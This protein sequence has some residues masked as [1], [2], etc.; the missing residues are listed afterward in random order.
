[1]KTPHIPRFSNAANAAQKILY[2]AV[3]LVLLVLLWQ[4]IVSF[5]LVPSYL[6]PSPMQVLKALV[7]DASLL[8][9][10]SLITLAEALLGLFWGVVFGVLFAALMDWIEPFKK[11]LR[12][13]LT[14]TQAV[15]TVAI[16][17]L[18]VLWLGYGML[19]KVVLVALTCFF[20][21]AISLLEGFQA[22]SAEKHE[23]FKTMRASKLQTFLYLK[24][25]TSLTYFFSGLKVGAAYAIVGAVIAEWLGGSFGLGVY[26]T[27]VR[28]SYAYDQMFAVILVIAALSLA[29]VGIVNILEKIYMPWEHSRSKK[30]CSE[31]GCGSLRQKSWARPREIAA[32]IFTGALAGASALLCVLACIG[33]GPFAQ[34][35]FSGCARSKVATVGK[36]NQS[37]GP[38]GTNPANHSSTSV[39]FVLD[40]TPNTNH[41]GIYAALE[42]GFYADAGI[43]LQIVQ[44]PEDGAEAMVGSG[45][46]DFG[47]SYQDTLA[48]YLFADEPVP[49]T[50]VAAVVQHNTSGIMSAAS[51]NIVRPRDLEA[52]TYATMQSKTEEAILKHLIEADGGDFNTVKLVPASA[53]DEVSGLKAQL[54]DAIW[55]F[56]GWGVQNAQLKDFPVRFMRIADFNPAFD[57][58]TPVIIA[59]NEFLE[60]NPD[61]AHCFLEATARGYT[62]AAAHP[63]EAVDC[64][65]KAAPETDPALA[66]ASADFLASEFI[67]DAPYWG[68]IDA[69]R[70]NHFYA[71]LD[72]EGLLQNSLVNRYGSRSGGTNY[73]FTNDFLSE[74]EG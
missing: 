47:M 29:L 41:L 8:A 58:Y 39:T 18:L 50:A 54:F 32:R 53:T 9:T 5:G 20:P 44:P 40:Y 43:N 67:S 72:E 10:Q 71:W 17:P 51:Q 45:Q 38:G 3:A 57:Y 42:E 7:K 6:L 73:G 25:P 36:G 37:S 62:F 56:Q 12:P 65:L 24:I 61:V 14:L 13:L 31:V 28:K 27:R 66:Y 30:R 35:G 64:L 68:Y 11:A 63:K 33:V 60:K 48:N 22:V 19:P 23:L 4:A 21:I 34:N 69:D 52:K 70:W 49:V 55:S 59:N 46:A 16:A 15:P 26:M 2:P 74:E 1:M